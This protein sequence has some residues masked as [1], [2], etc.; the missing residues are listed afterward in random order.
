M[1]TNVVFIHGNPGSREIFSRF[2]AYNL[3]AIFIDLPG[4]GYSTEEPP[5]NLSA[6]FESCERQILDF[7]N[8]NDE[9]WFIS[10]DWGVPV[11]VAIAS[12]HS[13]KVRGFII[14]NTALGEFESLPAWLRFFKGRRALGPVF[15]ALSALFGTLKDR[16]TILKPYLN[17]NVFNIPLYI[18]LIP[19]TEPERVI[20]IHKKALTENIFEKDCLIIWGAKDPCLNT[21][22][23]ADVFSRFK[24]SKVVLISRSHF[25]PSNLETQEVDLVVNFLRGQKLS[26]DSPLIE[27]LDETI[28][29]NSS[30]TAIFQVEGKEITPVSFKEINAL[31]YKFQ[32]ELKSLNLRKK[33]VLFAFRNWKQFVS[34][35]VACLREKCI[36]VLIDP[37]IEL[38]LLLK[39]LRYL[40]SFSSVS[41]PGASL[42][43]AALPFQGRRVTIFRGR[44]FGPNTGPETEIENCAF[45]AF[46]SGGTGVPKP[47]M[48]TEEMILS[49]MDI[50]SKRLNMVEY[51]VDL[52][53]TPAF[54]LFSLLLGRASILVER[55][56]TVLDYNYS[57]LT[58]VVQT[59]KPTHVFASK[60]FWRRFV[61]SAFLN[62]VNLSFISHGVL[63]GAPIY[64][65]Y[66]K[67]ILELF[68]GHLIGAYGS[69]EALPVS[70][71]S[72]RESLNDGPGLYVGKP[73]DEIKARINQR[74]QI[75]VSGPNV[76]KSYL[77]NQLNV[78]LKVEIDGDL[79]H[80][81]SDVGVF[82]D[83]ELYILGRF[84][85]SIP[86]R[87]LYPYPIEDEIMLRFNVDECVCKFQDNNLNLYLSSPV[88]E[89]DLTKLVESLT[90]IS[91][92][93]V[94]FVEK[95]PYD[96]RH[97]SKVLRD[98]LD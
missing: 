73:I 87:N 43:L 70:F 77:S 18:N 27:R 13:K 84:K 10:H 48:F 44:L 6:L 5:T 97:N 57:D 4:L 98:R 71:Y 45:V 15:L 20:D 56:R 41:S 22:F 3:N 81:M 12:K 52:P 26:N 14:F 80:N 65:K 63:S 76:S 21:F 1:Q 9:I 68:D 2:Q 49:Q 88:P 29:Q 7:V 42:I 47:V 74:N 11:A 91:E 28:R 64:R 58:A 66:A 46:T 62:K 83:G 85:D 61:C 35:F 51:G 72:L 92:I 82:K 30:R 50:F 86:E 75:L 23:L 95:F 38:S 96:L 90:G 93:N 33:L 78:E 32:A 37:K 89:K 19:F 60:Y 25:A 34:L 53:I 8:K 59:L 69:T 40:P 24:N 67:D 54:F 39:G 55:I 36:P 16:F 94:K 79:F 17:K 31:A